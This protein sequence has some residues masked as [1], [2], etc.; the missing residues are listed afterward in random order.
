MVRHGWANECGTSQSELQQASASTKTIYVN[1]YG[2]NKNPPQF[3]K[4]NVVPV[5]IDS[6]KP[7]IIAYKFSKYGNIPNYT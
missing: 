7:K 4:Q 3:Y 6:L 1:T 2:A 5:F